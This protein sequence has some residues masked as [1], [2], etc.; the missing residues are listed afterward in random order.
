ME[1]TVNLKSWNDADW[2]R[3]LGHLSGKP[4]IRH[5]EVGSYEGNSAIWMLE[6]IL[7]DP[8]ARITCVDTFKGGEGLPE[9]SENALL[10]RFLKN[11]EPWTEK[12]VVLEG[13]SSSQLRDIR[14]EYQFDSAYIDGSHVAANVLT[15]CV[16][17]WML[18]KPGAI[19][20][21]DDYEWPIDPNPDNRPKPAINAFLSVFA[22]QYQLID[23]SYQ[24]VLKK[25]T[26]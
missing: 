24:V 25:G 17:V 18:L 14:L 10:D 7:T 4:G 5:L 1:F 22:G 23:K 3:W 11:T 21:L 20:I 9:S 15:D 2:K 19:L 12:I 6:N 13:E 8:T 26:P 16:L